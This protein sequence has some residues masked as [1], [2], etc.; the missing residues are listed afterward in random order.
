MLYRSSGGTGWIRQEGWSESDLDLRKR[1]GVS[2]DS[3]G[4]VVEVNLRDN[5]LTGAVSESSKT[6]QDHVQTVVLLPDSSSVRQL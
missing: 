2:T 6:K 4:R 1:H 5:A 3:D